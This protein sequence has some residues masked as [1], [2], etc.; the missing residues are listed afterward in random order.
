MSEQKNRIEELDDFWDISQIVPIKRKI[1]TAKRHVS[2]VEI[3]DEADTPSEQNSQLAI[4]DTVIRRFIPPHSANEQDIKLQELCTYVPQNSLIHKVTLYK[5]PTSYSFYE[6]FCNTARKLWYVQG[7]K[8]DYADYFSYSPQ[9]DQL[10]RAQMSYYLWWRDNVRRNVY[11]TTNTCYISLYTFELINIDGLT[12]PE[13]TREIMI[14]IFMNYKDLLRGL[15]PRYVKWI[16]DYSLIHKLPPPTS[17]SAELLKNAGILKEYFVNV[18]GNTPEGWASTLLNYC[19][20]YDYRSSKFAKGDDLEL[21]DKHVLGAL[22]RCVEFLS[23]NGRILSE[24]PFGDCKL[25]SKAYEGAI[26]SSENRVTVEVAYCSFSRSHELRFLVGDIVKYAENK[27]RAHILIKSRLTVY[28][29]PNELRDIIDGYFSVVLPVSRKRIKKAE[30]Q[31]YDAFYDLPRTKLSLQNAE[32]IELESWDTTK[33]LVEEF[34]DISVEESALQSE[35]NVPQEFDDVEGELTLTEAL[36]EY[37]SVVRALSE[38]N[39]HTLSEFARGIGQTVEALVD[40]INEIAVDTI[41]DILIDEGQ[42][43]F[44]VIDDYK[45][46]LN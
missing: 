21:F 42:D 45:D 34:D 32:K 10:S 25:T 16:C 2:A 44:C 38:G 26:C 33:E 41:G 19:C 20:S 35:S 14:N 30:P 37:L 12:E 22:M 43:G 18:P 11:L 9:Y 15:A 23:K 40:R 29:L 3:T 5:Q 36:G 6:E 8:C 46:M 1:D 7:E 31:E 17:F 13:Q 4:S 28:S 27:I 24:L 39:T